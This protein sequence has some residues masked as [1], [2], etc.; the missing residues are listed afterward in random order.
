MRAEAAELKA[1]GLKVADTASS[2]KRE[3]KAIPEEAFGKKPKGK[4]G[5]KNHAK[6]AHKGKKVVAQTPEP[7]VKEEEEVKEEA[8]PAAP[9]APTPAQP[10]VQWSKGEQRALEKA[11]KANPVSMDKKDR[12]L[13]ISKAVNA[14]GEGGKSSRKCMMRFKEIRAQSQRTAGL[15]NKDDR[16]PEWKKKQAAEK[17]KAK[18]YFTTTQDPDERKKKKMDKSDEKKNKFKEAAK[19]QGTGKKKKKK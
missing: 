6:A 13:A 4:K 12:W 8:A 10:V 11:L 19:A 16:T 5:K 9:A 15:G 17:K 18:G 1:K 14:A 7:E 2:G 3:K